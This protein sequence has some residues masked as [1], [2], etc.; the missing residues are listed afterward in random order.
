[1]KILLSTLA[2]LV[3]TSA[4]A[5]YRVVECYQ[6]FDCNQ[7]AKKHFSAEKRPSYY[8]PLAVTA[9][10]TALEQLQVGTYTGRDQDGSACQLSVEDMRFESEQKLFDEIDRKYKPVVV[11]TNRMAKLSFNTQVFSNP[12]EFEFN[13]DTSF[14]NNQFSIK[15][16]TRESF[17]YQLA[18]F[19]S[20]YANVNI[21]EK[22]NLVFKLADMNGSKIPLAAKAQVNTRRQ[23]KEKT[24][25]V[26]LKKELTCQF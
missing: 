10:G 3:S 4:I 6:G 17:F 21:K 5:Q 8:A 20:D 18:H 25:T 22:V 7:E 26:K 24:S 12:I 11:V 16:D 14:S 13:K 15:Y 9:A 1:M 23:N 19:M 2:L